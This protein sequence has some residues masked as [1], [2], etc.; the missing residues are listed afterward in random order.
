MLLTSE[1]LKE[2]QNNIE[3]AP[4]HNPHNLRGIEACMRHMPT[5]PQVGVFDTA[6]HQQMQR[7][8]LICMVYLMSY[9]EDIK[10]EDMVSMEPRTIL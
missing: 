4:L 5:T 6:F 7:L 3:L 1:V 8:M 10:S 9:I 2:V